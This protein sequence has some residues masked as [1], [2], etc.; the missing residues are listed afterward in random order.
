YKCTSLFLV[1]L[2]LQSAAVRQAINSVVQGSAADLIKRGMVALNAR[3][4]QEQLDGV[5]RLVLQVHDELLFEVQA[6][7]EARVA[8]HVQEVMSSAWDLRVPFPVKISM[9]PSWGELSEDE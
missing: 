3:L 5:A 2:Q 1:Y 7:H 9:G 4:Q 8:A 6:G